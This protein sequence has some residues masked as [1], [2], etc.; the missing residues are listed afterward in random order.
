MRAIT[1]LFL[2]AAALTASAQNNEYDVTRL[3]D[4]VYALI[5]REQPIHPEPNVLIVVNDNDVLVVD[6]CMFPGTARQII[7]EIKKLTSKPVRY[8]VNTHWHDDHVFG[9]FVYRETWP[10][11]EFIAHTNTRAD[12]ETKGFDAIKANLQSNAGL[13]DGARTMVKTGKRADGSTLDDAAKKRAQMLVN[14]YQRYA[15]E[16]PKVRPMLPNIT[17]DDSLVLR[18]GGRTIELRYLGR[19]NTRGDVVIYLPKEKILATGDLVVAPVPLG[20]GSF[21]KDWISTLDALMKFDATT[22]FLSHG[23]L[24]KDFS[25]VRNVR[26]LLAALVS[27][28]DAEVAARASLE[29]VQKRVTLDDWKKT[30]SGDDAMRQRMFDA[31]FVSAAVPRYYHQAKGEPDPN[32]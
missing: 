28:V 9:N 15:D 18:L 25:Y 30:L 19:G 11:V 7:S 17:F 2:A 27:R 23:A 12:A 24:Q 5:W 13:L 3:S 10:G 6:S 31:Y 26:E 20:L 21:Y 14:V 32:E 29:D 1:L 16:I 22:I 4:G 8:V